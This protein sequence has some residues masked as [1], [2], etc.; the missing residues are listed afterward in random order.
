MATNGEIISENRRY[1]FDNAGAPT[2]GRFGA[3]EAMYD[4][5]SIRHLSPLVTAGSRCLEVGAG[6]GSIALW[7][8]DRVGADGMVVATDINTRFL[9]GIRS[10][11]LEVR[12]HNIVR[13]EIEENAFDIVHTR[14][15]LVHLPERLEVMERLVRALKPGGWI[16]LQEFDSLSMMPDQSIAPSEH[17]FK[18][19]LAMWEL[20][21]SRG[22]DVR[23]GRALYPAMKAMGL[24][25]VWA[26]GHVIFN[27]GG[28]DGAHLLLANFTQMRDALIDSGAVSSQQFEADLQRLGDPLVMWPSSLLWT[29]IGRKAAV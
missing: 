26:E 17:M 12:L 2:A 16:I 13:D 9:E 20:M 1:V 22:V 6:S 3:L 8:S 23:F 28:S 25:N 11:N 27:Q 29:V 21:G 18:T 24:Q 19:L 14:L 5:V 15:V 10:P 7:M 4:P